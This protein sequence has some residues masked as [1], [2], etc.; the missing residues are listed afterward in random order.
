LNR[1]GDGDYDR[2]LELLNT[3][4]RNLLAT[5]NRDEFKSAFF[6]LVLIQPRLLLLVAK[7]LL[8][9]RTSR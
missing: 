9:M 7:S 5:H 2:L 1:F 3:R 6:R 8:S 4:T